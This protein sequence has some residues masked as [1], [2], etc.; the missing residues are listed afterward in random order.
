MSAGRGIGHRT[1]EVT[2]ACKEVTTALTWPSSLEEHTSS[3][4]KSKLL[5]LAEQHVC[6][7]NDLGIFNLSLTFSNYINKYHKKTADA[8]RK[9]ASDA[10]ARE[11]AMGRRLLLKQQEITRLRRVISD[12]KTFIRRDVWVRSGGVPVASGSKD[13]EKDEC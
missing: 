6:L 13:K 8:L 4:F 3:F 7:C 10:T 2:R 12:M 11:A 9:V 1:E 5:A